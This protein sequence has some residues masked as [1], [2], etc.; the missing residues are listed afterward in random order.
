MENLIENNT[1]SS[2]DVVKL[3]NIYRDSK[4]RR[5]KMH[6]NLLMTIRR[7]IDILTESQL[8]YR[9]YFKEDTYT[10]KNNEKR[11]CYNITKLGL[12]Y[13][14]SITTSSDKIALQKIL[15]YMGEE[16]KIIYCIDRFEDT[17]FG[18]LSDTLKAMNI[19]LERQK[20]VLGYRLDGYIP[21]YNLVIEY[22]E[23][24]HLVEPQR[25]KDIQRQMEIEKEL[26]CNFIRCD[27]KNTD[28]F[29]IGLIINKIIEI[30]KGEI[31]I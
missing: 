13:L 20:N 12:M 22:D 23:S 7:H 28:A 3:I 8:D 15:E 11:P 10:D 21:E 26:E 31:A 25:S 1:I 29:N 5:K 4:L 16:S 27:Y 17:F 14:F 19:T 24:Q 18:K 6:K 30:N 2:V 9:E